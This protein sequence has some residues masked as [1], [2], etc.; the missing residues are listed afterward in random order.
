MTFPSNYENFI[1][2]NLVSRIQNRSIHYDTS[3]LVEPTANYLSNASM[4]GKNLRT[5]SPKNKEMLSII[6]VGEIQGLEG[7]L[8]QLSSKYPNLEAHVY[9]YDFE[10]A[11]KASFN[12]EKPA[13]VASAVK[14]PILFEF[15]RKIDKSNG[16]LSINQNV[17]F[18]EYQ[19][20]SGSGHMQYNGTNRE[21]SFDRI[22]ELMITQS[23]NSATNIILD[24]IGGKEALNS[25]FRRWGLNNS[26]M[27]NWLPD[28]NGTN[29]MSAK[30]LATVLYNY[31]NPKFLST[32][33]REYIRKYMSNLPTHKLIRAGIPE[34]ALLLHKTGDIKSSLIDAGIIYL[35]NG[36]KY[37]LS[38]I[39]KR[40]SNDPGARNLIED[41]SKT[42]YET[43][44]R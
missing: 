33:S 29:Q 1:R 41:I 40:P 20:T 15:F 11:A 10:S 3:I 43:I 5:V 25:A 14:I 28:L 42:V 12:G 27:G 4:F 22:A 16:A 7:K 24:Y 18:E 35:P 13:P 8:A 23:D 31:D 44:N 39:V 34:N 2:P 32:S 9:V 30:D 6:P 26:I 38:V 37:I 19:K 21:Y 17:L 36:H